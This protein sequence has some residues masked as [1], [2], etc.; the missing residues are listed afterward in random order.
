MNWGDARTPLFFVSADSKEVR[1]SVS[2]T[3]ESK[4]LKCLRISRSEQF[5]ETIGRSASWGRALALAGW[6][7]GRI[8]GGKKRDQEKCSD[9]EVGRTADEDCA[10]RAGNV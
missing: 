8:P 1:G 5:A 2:V 9:R 4:D 3:Q 7:R 10:E 6:R